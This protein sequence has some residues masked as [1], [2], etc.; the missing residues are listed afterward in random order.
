MRAPDARGYWLTNLPAIGIEQAFMTSMSLQRSG[1]GKASRYGA[2][3]AADLRFGPA[4][5]MYKDWEGI[6]YP[7]PKPRGFDQL[8]Y[9]SKF[10]DAVEINS[11]FYGPPLATSSGNWVRRV[12]QNLNF[13]FTAKLWKRFTHE[14]AKAWTTADVDQVRAGF[15]VLMGSEKLGAVL[16]Q[17]PWSF[18]HTEQNR[19]WLGDV[20]RTFSLY[21][22]VVEVRHKS[23]LVPDFLRTLEE[24]GVGFVN[25]DQPLYHNSI[26]P[27]AHVTSHVGYVRV[28]GRNYKDWFREKAP[29]EQRYNYLYRADELAPWAERARQIA[30]DPATREVYVI[31]NNHYKGKAVANALMLKSMVRGGRVP[32]PS[33]VY[34]TY[35]DVLEDFA[36]PEEQFAGGGASLLT[37]RP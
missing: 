22:L 36:E 14:R 31:T 26:G 8:R 17:F 32:A 18:R 21:P 27:T 30:A 2:P 19:E 6:V 28:H 1:R 12:E 23:W 4:G 16:L 25:I 7:R 37:A 11:S 24:E 15:D 13:H 10:F 35:R 33:G 3:R 5:W 9:I 20:V 29:V 34:E